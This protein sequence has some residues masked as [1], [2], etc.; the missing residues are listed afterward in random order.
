MGFPDKVDITYVNTGR[1][2][3]LDKEGINKLK[4]KDGHTRSTNLFNGP[5]N[6]EIHEV[7]T[8]Y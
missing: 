4:L 7:G 1:Q 3:S 2:L 8:F 6:Y 5:G